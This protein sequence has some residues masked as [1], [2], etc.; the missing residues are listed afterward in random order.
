M[1]VAFGKMIT[2]TIPEHIVSTF[3]MAHN[4][5]VCIGFIAVFGLAAL[6]P[7]PK[8]FEANKSD[9]FWR[10]IW[11]APGVIGLIVIAMVLL[12]F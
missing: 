1:N 3:A 11:L 12:V 2:E 6:L 9:E 5:S 10:V 4:A 8:D 7:D